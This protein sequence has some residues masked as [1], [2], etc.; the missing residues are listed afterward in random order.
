MKTEGLE[1]LI[2]KALIECKRE[3]E[4]NLPNKFLQ[5]DDKTIRD[6]EKTKFIKKYKE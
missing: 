2:L 5:M 3:I 1:N 4:I 6:G